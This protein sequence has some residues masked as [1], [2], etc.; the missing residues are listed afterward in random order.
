MCSNVGWMH[1]NDTTNANDISIISQNIIAFMLMLFHI[2][3]VSLIS[4]SANH[5]KTIWKIEFYASNR[6]FRYD[7]I[8]MALYSICTLHTLHSMH[9]HLPGRF[10][11]HID[12]AQHLKSFFDDFES[13]SVII[14]K[15]KIINIVI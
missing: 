13:F 12:G 7:L 1:H 15:Q 10:Y 8:S 4:V 3:H 11:Q 14:C 5:P 9:M 2:Y 6:T